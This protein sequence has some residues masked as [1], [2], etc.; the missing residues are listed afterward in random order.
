M[1]YTTSGAWNAQH[2]WIPLIT[3]VGILS[4]IN[5]Q[6]FRAFSGD[7]LSESS[8]LC[9]QLG[10]SSLRVPRDRILFSLE[11]CVISRSDNMVRMGWMTRTRTT[12]KLCT[13]ILW[14]DSWYLHVWYIVRMTAVWAYVGLRMRTKISKSCATRYLCRRAST[15]TGRTSGKFETYLTSLGYLR[16][17][18]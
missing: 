11:S 13:K 4:Y 7:T 14:T 8:L 2:Q 3:S 17:L 12:R 10:C 5:V 16:L 1:M 15:K 6:I 9:M 18:G